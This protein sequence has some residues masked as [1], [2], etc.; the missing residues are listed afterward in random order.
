MPSTR[1]EVHPP[2]HRA[3]PVVEDGGDEEVPAEEVLVV[4]PGCE[5]VVGEGEPERPEHGHAVPL[6]VA[7]DLPEIGQQGV[8]EA[9]PVAADPERLLAERPRFAGPQPVRAHQR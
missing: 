1:R 7:R 8:A 6:H 2:G 5:R 4:D 9:D 3:D